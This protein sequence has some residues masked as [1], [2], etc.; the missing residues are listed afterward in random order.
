M[1]KDFRD[2]FYQS[3][4]V[5]EDGSPIPS[6]RLTDPYENAQNYIPFPCVGIITA[7]RLVDDPE[8]MSRL[9]RSPV[10]HT[11]DTEDKDGY[12]KSTL[13]VAD[14]VGPH[15]ECDVFIVKGFTTDELRL[16]GVPVCLSFGGIDNYVCMEDYDNVIK[17]KNLLDEN[18]IY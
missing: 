12:F 1:T 9:F 14:S 6:E 5:R 13:G 16:P 18:G 10:A 8:N 7:V 3:E 17:F 2:A 11:W 4:Q 15:V